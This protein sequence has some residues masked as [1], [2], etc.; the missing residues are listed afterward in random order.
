VNTDR[1]EESGL[2]LFEVRRREDAEPM[3]RDESH[4][5]FLNR[6]DTPYWQR[7]RDLLESW[8]EHYPF[9]ARPDLLRR[10]QAKGDDQ[11]IA[12]FWELYLHEA[13]HRSGWHLEVHPTLRSMTRRLDFLAT[14]DCE[15][16]LLEATAIVRP[17][18]TEQ[19][20]RLLQTVLKSVDGVA[21]N[22]FSLGVDYLSVGTIAPS[23][24]ELRQQLAAW[25][26]TL[27]RDAEVQALTQT[28]AFDACPKYHWMPVEGWHLLFRAY[29]LREGSSARVGF[30]AIGMS[31]PGKAHDVDHDGPLREKLGEK[32]QGIKDLPH[33]FVI[34]V[35]SQPGV[36]RGCWPSPLEW[37]GDM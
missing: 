8:F 35:A 26:A 19:Q 18:L 15:G 33:A 7:V 12:G 4:F 14:R 36:R 22:D 24:R 13:L 20:Q 34:A 23:T 2:R 21:T 25:L 37:D 3:R 30:R 29:P 27:D 31:S 32:L 1:V 10:F 6:V 16:L 11:H 9:D 17:L 28:N 5:A